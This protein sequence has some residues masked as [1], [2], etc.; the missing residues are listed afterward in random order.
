MTAFGKVINTDAD[1]N[2]AM[3]GS[4]AF[5]ES[6]LTISSGS[7]T[8]TRSA[9]IIAAETGTTDDLANIATGSVTD[10]AI[11]HIRPD[12]G[13]TITVKDAATG[14]GEIHLIDNA[15]FIM[16]GDE[17]IVL[18][19]RTPDWYEVGRSSTATGTILQVV[20][21]TLTST[22]TM[23]S[24]T[25]ADTGLTVNITPT[26]TS[27][28][29][30]VFVML[31]AGAAGSTATGASFR[32]VRDSTDLLVGDTASNRIRVST[33]GI[34]ESTASVSGMMGVSIN[35]LDSPSAS[36][37]TTYKVQWAV[38]NAGGAIYL[39]RTSTDTDNT[40]FPRGAC[41]IIAMEVKG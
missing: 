7:V 22:A 34:W 8:A 29:V 26:S 13:D 17:S 33:D 6:T 21:A 40:S 37:S 12:S 19:M 27:N 23:S 4:L 11:I 5:T 15:D 41:S 30:L 36:S 3:A 38:L 24:A 14:A 28:K 1:E 32:L 16:S 35:Y 25:F 10:G 18:Q 39:N 2:N 9:H 31:S 20:Q